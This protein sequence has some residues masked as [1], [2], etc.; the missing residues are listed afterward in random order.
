MWCEPDLT[1]VH[2]WIY[3]IFESR[4]IGKLNVVF[5]IDK[6]MMSTGSQ[7]DGLDS[8]D[9][10]KVQWHTD[11]DWKMG[12]QPGPWEHLMSRYHRIS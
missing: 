3:L 2:R 11:L 6:L 10:A 1:S 5:I 4:V 8:F 12:T 7:A 9:F